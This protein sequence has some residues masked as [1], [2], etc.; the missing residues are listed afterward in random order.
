MYILLFHECL[1]F[2]MCTDWLRS[3]NRENIV[4]FIAF[5]D[6]ILV[7]HCTYTRMIAEVVYFRVR[8]LPANPTFFDKKRYITLEGHNLWNI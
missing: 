8:F 4:T 1:Y 7:S 2:F 3:F 6:K 5:I